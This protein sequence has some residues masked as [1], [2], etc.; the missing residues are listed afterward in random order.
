MAEYLLGLTRLVGHGRAFSEVLTVPAPA[1]GVGFTYTNDG[2]Y[3]ELLDSISFRL[4]SDANAANRQVTLTITDGAGSA[5]ATLPSASLQVASKT[6]D[7]TFSPQFNTF[8][9]VVANA[10]TLPLPELFLQP[11]Y[12]IVV[13]IGA[14]QAGDQVSAI[15]LYAQRFVTGPSGYSIGMVDVPDPG[16]QSIIDLATVAA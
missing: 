6:Y 4:V 15:R 13:A 5:L 16:E 10:I 1:V 11:A 9:T 2:R 3:W 7:Y 12:S 14:V 8:N